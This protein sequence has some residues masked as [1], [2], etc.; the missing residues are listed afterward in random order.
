MLLLS[1][2][3]VV[4]FDTATA[5]SIMLCWHSAHV[6]LSAGLLMCP[7]LMLCCLVALVTCSSFCEFLREATVNFLFVKN[8]S[9]LI[10]WEL[11]QLHLSSLSENSQDNLAPKMTS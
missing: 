3:T 1:A 6:S 8:K 4:F 10:L 9:N 5:L 2:L 11:V 7:P